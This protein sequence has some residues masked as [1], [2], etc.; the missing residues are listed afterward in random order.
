MSAHS[1]LDDLAGHLFSKT[2]LM[3]GGPSTPW[4]WPVAALKRSAL[5]WVFGPLRASKPTPMCTRLSAEG[6]RPKILKVFS[7]HS[8]VLL[9]ILGSTT[10]CA[11]GSSSSNECKLIDE[12]ERMS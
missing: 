2:R 1:V 12:A 8:L 4:W 7:D 9:K 5:Y 10:T 6:E 3:T 11:T